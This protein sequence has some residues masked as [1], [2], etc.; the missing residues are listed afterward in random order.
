VPTHHADVPRDDTIRGAQVGSLVDGQAAG[1]LAGALMTTGRG[2]PLSLASDDSASESQL[3]EPMQAESESEVGLTEVG[4]LWHVQQQRHSPAQVSDEKLGPEEPE[5]SK[6][7]EPGELGEAGDAHR[8]HAA[9]EQT[10]RQLDDEEKG[11]LEQRRKMQRDADVVTEDM[12]EEVM[13]LLR[14][15]GLPYIVA[16]MEAEA[17][18]AVL[19]QLG[20]VHGVVTDD[21]DAFVFGAKTVYKNIFDDKKYVEAYL[22]SDVESEFGLGQGE[23]IALAMLLGSDYTEGIKGVGIV[24][25]MEILRAFPASNTALDSASVVSGL[26]DFKAW[27]DVFDPV[28]QAQTK[29]TKADLQ[30]MSE[31]ARFDAKHRNAK[32]KWVAGARFPDPHVAHAYIKPE[33]NKST[34]PF[35]WA[36][37]DLDGVRRYCAEMMGWPKET[38]DQTMR[39][40]MAQLQQADNQARLDSYYTTYH[41]NARFAKVQSARLRK[42]ISGTANLVVGQAAEEDGEE[43]SDK[44]RRRKKDPNAPTGVRSAYILFC[45]HSRMGIKAAAAPGTKATEIT[46]LLGARWKDMSATEKEKWN[47]EA[48]KDRE[49]FEREMAAYQVAS[50]PANKECKVVKRRKT[51]ARPSPAISTRNEATAGGDSQSGEEDWEGDG[52]TAASSRQQSQSTR[53]KVKYIESPACT[54]EDEGEDEDA[55]AGDGGAA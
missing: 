52:G 7:L 37:P 51:E 34:E 20:L 8:W 35:T 40:L 11:L 17:Q 10:L 36:S 53:E 50:T 4:K 18:C 19:E 55:V 22:A 27:M 3:K 14:L 1:A 16:P 25:A 31:V 12:R 21:S 39:P 32:L 46:V 6:E 15:F 2:M 13:E 30:G 29:P 23:M 41:D 43:A 28:G 24:N 33:V 42:A 44:K 9:S 54:S 49:R 5:K 38:T 45:Q 26:F 47:E 48:A